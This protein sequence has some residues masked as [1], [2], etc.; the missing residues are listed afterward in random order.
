MRIQKSKE[1]WEKHY[2]NWR[3]SGLS[4][5][6]YANDNKIKKSTFYGWINKFRDLDSRALITTV[7]LILICHQSN[8]KTFWSDRWRFSMSG[9][10]V[11]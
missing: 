8:Q 4:I 6:A 5:G 1:W 2:N 11:Y 9:Q 7:L 3:I 10:E